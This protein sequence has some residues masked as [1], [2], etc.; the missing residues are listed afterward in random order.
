MTTSPD[1]AST[2][3]AL[4]SLTADAGGL[5]LGVD[6]GGTK[7]LALLAR[8]CGDS[9]EVV[10]RGQAG[11]GN[12]TDGLDRAVTAIGAAIDLARADAG[13][14]EGP[15]AAAC[16]AVAGSG[17]ED[18]RLALERWAHA[19][20]LARGLLI[21]HD[22]YPVLALAAPE[23]PGIALI[24]GTGSIAFGRN[25]AGETARSGGW[26][27]V[28]GETGSGHGIGTAALRAVARAADGR[29]PDTQ[30]T[31]DI[32]AG[33]GTKDLRSAVAVLHQSASAPARVARIAATVAAA[34]AAGDAVARDILQDAANHLG[35]IVASVA[36]RL[37]LGAHEYPLAL[38]GGVLL[39]DPALREMLQECLDRLRVSPARIVL[40]DQP[41]V[42]AVRLARR[43]SGQV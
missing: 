19:R 35:S 43:C 28:V 34:A 33:L 12:I 38:A 15:F 37:G 9:E 41:A 27:W 22:A 7:T 26:G 39:H 13:C 3:G 5:L 14:V 25:A 10:G 29:G 1:P 4:D 36:C 18:G 17:T 42:G 8:I 24:A 20:D 40:V 23:G 16:L 11:P 32:L 30:L 31:R 21:V 6:A 2:R